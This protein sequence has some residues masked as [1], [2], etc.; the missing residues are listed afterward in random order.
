M[1][2][3]PRASA[4]SLETTFVKGQRLFKAC[5]KKG[6][7]VIPLNRTGYRFGGAWQS[8]KAEDSKA[9]LAAGFTGW[10]SDNAKFEREFER[11]GK[12]LRAADGARDA[13]SPPS[14]ESAKQVFLRIVRAAT[15][16]D[17]A[18]RSGAY[19]DVG[20]KVTCFKYQ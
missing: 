15:R 20:S 8:G 19:L 18:H 14:C 12:V 1:F 17:T 3:S 6:L 4:C 7:A 16:A 13:P 10:E 11:G 2:P 5:G 9:R